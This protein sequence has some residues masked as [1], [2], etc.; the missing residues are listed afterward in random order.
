MTTGG[1]TIFGR[2]GPVL[3]N[4]RIQQHH[5]IHKMAAREPSKYLARALPRAFAPSARSQVFIGRRN[6]SDDAP[7]RRLSDELEAASSLTSKVS[8]S[9]AK[10]F[11]PVSRANARKSQLPRSRYVM[12]LRSF[13]DSPSHVNYGVSH[14]QHKLTMPSNIQIPVPIP[15]I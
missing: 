7:T 2:D 8:D 3:M 15:E 9:A 12:M 1:Q 11:D 4:L 5:I 10:S 6:A 14:D 13:L